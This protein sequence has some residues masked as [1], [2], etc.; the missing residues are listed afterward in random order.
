MVWTKKEN[1]KCS[2]MYCLVAL[3][4]TFAALITKGAICQTAQRG[5]SR[6]SGPGQVQVRGRELLRDGQRWIP[7]GFYQ[8]AVE[9]APGN[10]NRADHPFWAIVYSRYTPE[11]YTEMRR[12]CADSVRLQIAQAD[13]DRQSP[14]FDREFLDKALGA[15]RAARAAGL[16]V[17]V[18]VQD[19]SGSPQ[20]TEIYVR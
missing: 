9:V 8:I 10:L 12:A 6:Q 13:A 18:C 16:T 17:I 7:H 4:G 11:E 2:K 5:L 15:I 3:F 20:E 1:M 19:E 14:L